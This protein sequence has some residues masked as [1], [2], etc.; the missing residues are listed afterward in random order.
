[1]FTRCNAAKPIKA[2]NAGG[3]DEVQEGGYSKSSSDYRTA[4]TVSTGR[5]V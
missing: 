1:M 4:A 5:C 3:N 2:R